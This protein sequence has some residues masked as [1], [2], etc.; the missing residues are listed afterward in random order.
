[1]Y[2]FN[3]ILTELNSF[4]NKIH[5]EIESY[6]IQANTFEKRAKDKADIQTDIINNYRQ[7]IIY[8][9]Y[10]KDETELP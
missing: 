3:K 4:D 8:R 2:K 9:I 6:K 10:Q 5:K 7:K 1:M